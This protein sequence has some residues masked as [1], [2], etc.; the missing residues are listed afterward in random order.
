[1]ITEWYETDEL[2]EN[3]IIQTVAKYVKTA[4]G[5]K[6]DQKDKQQIKKLYK[7]SPLMLQII[8][9]AFWSEGYESF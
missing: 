9:S 4:N 7:E 8:C 2:S 6:L 3:Q 5:T 1:M